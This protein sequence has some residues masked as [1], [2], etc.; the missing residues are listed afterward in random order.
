V[1]RVPTVSIQQEH[2]FGSA[3]IADWGK[4][5]RQAMLKYVQECFQKVGGANKTVEIDD[6]KFG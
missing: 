2:H 5:C 3:T 1:R 4:F 6:S